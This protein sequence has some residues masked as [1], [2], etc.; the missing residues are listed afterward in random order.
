MIK[1]FIKTRKEMFAARKESLL[2]KFRKEEGKE[3]MAAMIAQ[4]FAR[5]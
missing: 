5:K 3:N 1:D 4:S 2:K